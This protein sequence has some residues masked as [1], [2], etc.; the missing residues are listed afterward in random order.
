MI[1]TVEKNLQ[2]SDGIEP[3]SLGLQPNALTIKRRTRVLAR[4]GSHPQAAN[5]LYISRGTGQLS[6]VVT[7]HVPA[8]QRR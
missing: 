6:Q 7:L 2:G 8:L 4:A 1:E 3:T 5:F